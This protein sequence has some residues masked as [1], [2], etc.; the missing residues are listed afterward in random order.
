MSKELFIAAHEQLVEEYLEK[1]PDATEPQAYAATADAAWD[2]AAD[3]LGNMID[4]ARMLHKER[5]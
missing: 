5:T 2:R 3:N 1:Y 4:R